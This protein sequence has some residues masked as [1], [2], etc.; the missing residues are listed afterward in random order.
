MYGE[1]QHFFQIMLK[2]M[3]IFFYNSNTSAHVNISDPKSYHGSLK[4]D[5][6]DKTIRRI[7]Y[8]FGSPSHG[9]CAI[10][11]GYA[12]ALSHKTKKL[13]KLPLP[14]D[15]PKKVKYLNFMSSF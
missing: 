14:N 3:T 5:F 15:P 12:M 10:P 4:C 1:L 2:A 8:N 13:H 11:E 6:D 9:V 7:V